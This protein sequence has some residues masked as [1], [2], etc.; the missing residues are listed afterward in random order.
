MKTQLPSTTA[1]ACLC[2]F[3]TTASGTSAAPLDAWSWRHPLP[4]GND[5]YAA[6]SGDGKIVV[7]GKK[8]AKGLSADGG[9]T[10]QSVAVDTLDTFGVAYGAGRF[11]TVGVSGISNGVTLQ[12]SPDGIHW[13]QHAVLGTNWTGF[14][15][16]RLTDVAFGNGQFIAVGASSS[17][18]LVSSNGMDWQ[19]RGI[20][21]GSSITRIRFDGTKF[22]A[23][24]GWVFSSLDGITWTVVY[25][26]WTV[27]DAAF[28]DGTLVGAGS[29]YDET[30]QIIHIL[31]GI[32]RT[33]GTVAV[34]LDDARP[35]FYPSPSLRVAFGNGRFV[36]AGTVIGLSLLY[37]SPDGVTWQDHSAAATDLLYGVAFVEGQFVAMGNH[38][39]LLTS[40]DGENWT[41]NSAGPRNFRSLTYGNGLHV[42]VGN[43]GLLMTSPDAVT[44]TY[45]TIPTTNNLRGV[46]Y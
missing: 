24:N 22:L 16:P 3:L 28:G 14:D 42:A 34:T 9:A 18:G 35:A 38:G 11:V 32:V 13:T 25:T 36:V 21:F 30:H 6:A 4:Q 10:W 29:F 5:L 31:A 44:W 37:T 17:I 12:S 46:V 39:I 19:P 41:G 2:A 1:L 23:L 43:D 20:G 27:Q 7:V 26:G 33:N 45:Q 8:G 15:G 40:P